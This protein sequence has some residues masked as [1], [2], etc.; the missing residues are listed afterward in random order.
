MSYIRHF[1]LWCMLL[2]CCS[3]FV[4]MPAHAFTA[5][6]LNITVEKNGDATATF[7]F[8]LEGIIE[9]AIPQSMLEEELKK[10]LTTSSEPPELKSMDKSGAVLLL[11][12]FADTSDVPTGTEYRTATMDFK[13]AEVALQNSALSG[14]VSADFSPATV[15]LTFPDSYRREFANVDV[16]PA[17]FHT[18]E[19][20]AKIAAAQAAANA[21]AGATPAAAVTAAPAVTG[22]MNV[23]STPLNVKVYIDANYAGEAPSVFPDIPPGTHTVEFRKE[24]FEPVQKNVTIL[25][26]KTTNVMVVLKYIPLAIPETALGSDLI[27]PVFVILIIAIAGSAIYYGT[28]LQKKK[29]ED[30]EKK[31]KDEK[32][33][34][35]KEEERE[36]IENSW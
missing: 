8:T 17:V 24:G 28:T 3:S 12:K 2:A 7:R 35:G 34:K 21:Q 10:G 9:N 32:D 4:N 14:A 11:K 23:T 30:G 5:N 27:L 31:D 13:K 6:S 25:T 15:V 29:E 18:V 22:A 1:I 26:G 16:L 19:D 33:E 36:K 20:P